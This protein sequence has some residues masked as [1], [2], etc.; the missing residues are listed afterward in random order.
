MTDW[1]D[2]MKKQ[3]S[4]YESLFKSP[5]IYLLDEAIELFLGYLSHVP[6]HLAAT[7]QLMTDGSV[8]PR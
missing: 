1:L 2:D 8:P 7:E 3:S 4:L 5:D 6:N